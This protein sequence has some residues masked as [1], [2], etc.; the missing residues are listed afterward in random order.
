M[1]FLCLPDFPPMVDMPQHA[2]Q[3]AALKGMIEGKFLW[4]DLV[5]F[6]YFTPYWLGYGTWLLLAILFP[7]TVATKL[8]LC[9]TF[10]S[11]VLG[12]SFLRRKFG[13]PESLDWLL[14][15]AFFGLPYEWGFL[16]FLLSAPIGALFYHANIRLMEDEKFPASWVLLLGVILAFAHGL[17]FAFFL[18]VVVMHL[19]SSEGKCHRKR[20]IAVLFA[21]FVLMLLFMVKGDKLAAYD[22]AMNNRLRLH[23]V[24]AKFSNL[25]KTVPSGFSPEGAFFLFVAILAAPFA[26]GCKFT[27]KAPAFSMLMC[28]LL[29]FA[30]LPSFMSRTGF[31]YQRF[32][33]L[34][35]PAYLLCFEKKEVPLLKEGLAKGFLCVLMLLLMYNPLSNLVYFRNE[36][37]A[38]KSLLDELPKGKRAMSLVTGIDR[39]DISIN[40]LHFPVWYQSIGDGWVD[41]NFAWYYPQP[42]RFRTD[43]VPE[44]K[45]NFEWNP[46]LV[47]ILKRC[48]IYDMIFVRAKGIPSLENTACHLHQH[49]KTNGNWHVFLKNTQRDGVGK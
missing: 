40:F 12:F 26:L 44:I 15:P 49:Y 43:S 47:S 9:L 36:S 3:V 41:F 38:F 31:I 10:V 39:Q 13:A 6:N 28:F 37:A 29:V 14:I 4:G 7:M 2:A 8:M 33:L 20:S 18:F 46:A 30:F 27:R 16:T 42:I 11:F 34:L 45:P 22:L 19:A 24:S 1:G 5:E 21:L 48:D 17:M 23:G 32:S 35:I 25:M